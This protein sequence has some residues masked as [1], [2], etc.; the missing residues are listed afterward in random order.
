MKTQYE[1]TPSIVVDEKAIVIQV[2]GAPKKVIFRRITAKDLIQ[3][4][5]KNKGVEEYELIAKYI[6]RL[7][8]EPGKLTYK[9]VESLDIADF[10]KL[11]EFMTKV[12]GMADDEEEDE[13]N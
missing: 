6:E 13:G 4:E 9:E 12:S 10:K 1:D 8:V 11:S 3:M 5:R 2:Q 7:S